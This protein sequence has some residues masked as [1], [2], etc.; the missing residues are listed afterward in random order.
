MGIMGIDIS[1]LLLGSTTFLK[2]IG[3]DFLELNN[4]AKPFSNQRWK[5]NYVWMIN[6]TYTFFENTKYILGDDRR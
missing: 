4:L 3:L 6:M 5:Y 2:N 1:F